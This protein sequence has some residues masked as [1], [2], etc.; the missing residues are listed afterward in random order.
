MYPFIMGKDNYDQ[1]VQIV[2]IFGSEE[3]LRFQLTYKSEINDIYKITG[4]HKIPLNNFT[5]SKYKDLA[6]NNALDLISKMLCFD[7][8]KRISASEALSHPYFNK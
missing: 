7:P 6:T 2:N 1:L 3:L 5:N 8:V 4:K